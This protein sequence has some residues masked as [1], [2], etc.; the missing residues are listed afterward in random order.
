M[1]ENVAMIDRFTREISKRDTEVN[2]LIGL[3]VDDIF[4]D[5]QREGVIVLLK[6]LKSIGMD[7]ERM[8]HSSFV[9]DAPVFYRAKLDSSI[10]TVMVKPTSID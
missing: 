2:R 9:D 3:D 1:V 10:D 8:V 6:D 7:M 5:F 4:P